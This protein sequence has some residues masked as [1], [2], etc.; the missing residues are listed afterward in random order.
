MFVRPR[1]AA[2]PPAARPEAM[3]PVEVAHCGPAAEADECRAGRLLEVAAGALPPVVSVHAA[4]WNLANTMM[5]V[6]IM[7]LAGAMAGVGVFGAVAVLVIFAVLTFSTVMLLIDGGI[8]SGTTSYEDL[9]RVL[10]GRA[11]EVYA[12]ASVLGVDIMAC[13]AFLV[14]V[15]DMS[16]F[17]MHHVLGTPNDRWHRNVVLVVAT[18]AVNLPMTFLPSIGALQYTSLLAIVCLAWF[19]AMTLVLVFGVETGSLVCAEL[20]VLPVS[21]PTLSPKDGSDAFA[22]ICCIMSSF[23]CQI[24]V[25]PIWSEM[26]VGDAA[27]GLPAAHTR[28]RFRTALLVALS[29]C[30]L[31]Y[32]GAALGGYF[33]FFD[34]TTKVDVI[35]DCYDPGHWYVLVAYV[36]MVAVCQFSYPLVQFSGRLVLLRALGYDDAATA[37]RWLYAVV[38][39]GL[40][41]VTAVPAAFVEDLSTVLAVGTALTA[42]PVVLQLPSLAGAKLGD[43]AGGRRACWGLL[44]FG[45]FM[46]VVSLAYAKY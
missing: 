10:A 9:A 32:L 19:V 39:L 15:K 41:A 4:V 43:T 30:S 1:S 2:R 31:L 8:S 27:R 3:A 11:G 14:S 40:L 34:T 37:P 6:G 36:G 25:F 35:L 12:Q 28:R 5:G 44:T 24:S 21:K 26:R 13:I 33:T 16:G 38:G 45:V 42:A 17:A 20:G 22:A 29:M 7:S 18:L 46:H 23:I